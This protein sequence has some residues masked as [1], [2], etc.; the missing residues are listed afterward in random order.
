MEKLKEEKE[1]GQRE[2]MHKGST[3]VDDQSS[4]IPS[5]TGKIEELC[6]NHDFFFK[7]ANRPL[8]KY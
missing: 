6:F 4:Q 3:M 1:G 7:A 2:Y 5:H 8:N